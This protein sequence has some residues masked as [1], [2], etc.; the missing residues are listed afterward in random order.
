MTLRERMKE[1]E[2]QSRTR[3]LRR[4]PVIIRLDGCHFHTWTRGLDRP[5]DKE[6]MQIMKNTMLTLCNKIQ[7]CALGYTQSDEITLVLVDYQRIESMAWYDNQV[8]K[9]CSVAASIATSAFEENL[10]DQIEAL[11]ILAQWFNENNMSKDE[12]ECLD[13]AE[14]LTSKRFKANFDARAFNIPIHEVV[15]NLIWRQQDCTRNSVNLLAQSLY[16]HKELQG[17]NSKD[18][19]D[20][21]FTEKGINWNEQRTDFKRGA[22]AIKDE[23]GKWF[24]DT[25]IPILTENREYIRKLV[26]LD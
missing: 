9:I 10:E 20:K 5:F 19:Q 23:E 13:K 4:V 16:P 24:I 26:D 7:G 15:N 18:L 2:M 21:M 1:Y 17:I 3:L 12:K 25:E 11:N 14:L 6:L 8:Q 22:C